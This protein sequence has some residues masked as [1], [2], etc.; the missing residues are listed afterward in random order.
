MNEI[1]LGARAHETREEGMCA[2]EFVAW[3]AN[4]P[5]TDHPA[6]VDYALGWFFI[7]L[8]DNLDDEE[9]QSLK[10]YLGR[11]LGTKDD[12]LADARLPIYREYS[13][14]KVNLPPFDRDDRHAQY[15]GIAIADLD[16]SARRR[17]LDRLL[18]TEELPEVT[19]AI[20]QKVG[21]TA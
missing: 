9:R 19:E 10:P 1:V 16:A 17:I 21:V 6:C 2:M 7:G 8:N 15:A 18:P 3:V 13:R 14:F 11:C 12:G 5:H 20:R 4:E